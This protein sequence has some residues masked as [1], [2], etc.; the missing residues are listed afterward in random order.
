MNGNEWSEREPNE[1]D[2]MAVLL[3]DLVVRLAKRLQ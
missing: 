3:A 1:G 2:E